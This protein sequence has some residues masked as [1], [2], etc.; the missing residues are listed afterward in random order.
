MYIRFNPFKNMFEMN[1]CFIIAKKR[2]NEEAYN[3]KKIIEELRTG[4]IYFDKDSIYYNAIS[5]DA[6]TLNECF[7]MY[8]K[9]N[10]LIIGET[11]FDKKM[12]EVL[13]KELSQLY[14][15]H[16]ETKNREYSKF[17]QL[18]RQFGYKKKTYGKSE[19]QKFTIVKIDTEIE[20]KER[21]KTK[22]IIEKNRFVPKE[23]A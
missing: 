20:N 21:N 4:Q 15:K 2:M 10:N 1:N 6:Y 16:P 11:I 17:G 7:N 8:M 13:H 23:S 9:K 22:A 14:N 19:N 12:E 5:F 18:L 3:F